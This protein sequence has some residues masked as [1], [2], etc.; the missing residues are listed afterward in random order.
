M[1]AVGE[2]LL[3]AGRRWVPVTCAAGASRSGG[4]HPVLHQHHAGLDAFQAQNVM[5]A[6][7][8]LAGNGRTV[9]AT[10]HQASAAGA[11]R[12]KGQRRTPLLHQRRRRT[13]LLTPGAL[14]RFLPAAA[15][16]YL[17]HV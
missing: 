1:D 15:L 8:T 9:I 10:I 17:S 14:L 4:A 13:L 12:G 5:E 3:G 6:L 16:L 2:A 11:C 7:W